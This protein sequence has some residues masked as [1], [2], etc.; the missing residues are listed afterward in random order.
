MQSKLKKHLEDP[1]EIENGQPAQQRKVRTLSAE[2]RMKISR[3]RKG[4]IPSAETKMRMSRAK[5]GKPHSEETKLLIAQ[6]R[7]GTTHSEE[8]KMRISRA[9][10]GRTTS[11][12]TKKKQSIAAKKRTWSQAVKDKMSKSRKGKP[13]TLQWRMRR[14]KAKMGVKHTEERKLKQS[15]SMKEYWRKKKA[16][17]QATESSENQRALQIN[18]KVDPLVMEK[19][20]LELAEVK[21]H[22][23][24]WL[25][26]W[27]RN[28]D[29]SEK[30]TLDDAA[31]ASPFVYEC[32]VRYLA[33][34]DFVRSR[35][36]QD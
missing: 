34:I 32:F 13:Q 10:T 3:S 8:T 20:L 28:H 4:Q 23:S 12:E 21:R 9:L 35:D 11:A 24:E 19:A 30:P 1:D 5:K 14:S 6:A 25:R 16:A 2:T 27:Y 33:L 36:Q 22:I 31:E 29:P 7:K 18:E 26:E 15:A 17:Q